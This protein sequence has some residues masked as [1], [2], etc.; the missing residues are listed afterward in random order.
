M[1]VSSRFFVTWLGGCSQGVSLG[2]SKDF[3]YFAASAF[4]LLFFASAAGA[5]ESVIS[6]GAANALH[7]SQEE[8]NLIM[9]AG[10]LGWGTTE[11]DFEEIVSADGTFKNLR[12]E[13]TSAPGAGKSF[14]FTVRKNNTDT[15]LSCSVSDLANECSDLSGSVAV[16][17]GDVVALKCSPTGTPAG[18]Q[19]SWSLIFD[20]DADGETLM[21]S[22]SGTGTGSTDGAVHTFQGNFL[23]V[24]TRVQDAEQVFPTAGTLENFYTQLDS[25]P[26]AGNGYTFTVY[27]NG[28]ATSLECTISDA[29]VACQDTMHSVAFVAGD[30][31]HIQ[32]T[33]IS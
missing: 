23:H 5:T 12:V 3:F 20:G 21:M 31:G 33:K 8:Y 17:A 11:S 26:G 15:A 18:G 27:K 24:E 7:S 14:V 30:T 28:A 32:V 19:A 10:G 29:A 25:A 2:Y 4:F 16:S 6:S 1:P 9:G 13:L 22:T